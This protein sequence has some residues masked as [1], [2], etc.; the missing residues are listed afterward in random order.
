MPEGYNAQHATLRRFYDNEWRR[1][2][3]KMRPYFSVLSDGE[4]WKRLSE[5]AGVSVTFTSTLLMLSFK[6]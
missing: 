6:F 3:L 2:I 5:R 4:E 1:M